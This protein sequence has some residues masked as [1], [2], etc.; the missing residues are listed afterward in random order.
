MRE[1]G[2]PSLEEWCEKFGAEVVAS[3]D[4]AVLVRYGSERWYVLRVP[5]NS[6]ETMT[7]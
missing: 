7:R 6:N 2:F 5:A 4:F 1:N 3:A